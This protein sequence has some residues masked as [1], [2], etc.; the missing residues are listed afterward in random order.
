MAEDVVIERI[1]ILL[2]PSNRC[3]YGVLPHFS[4]SF[5]A[6]LERLGISCRVLGNEAGVTPSLI[7]DLLSDAPDCTLSFNGLLPDEG[8]EFF[9][10]RIG[11]PHVACLVDSPNK[12]LSLVQSPLNIITC[13]DQE[14]SS[15]FQKLGHQNTLFMPHAV[16]RDLKESCFTKKIYDVVFLGTCLDIEELSGRWVEIFGKAVATVLHEAAEIALSD[17]VSHLSAFSTALE[18]RM[19]RYGDID[20]STLDICNLLDQLEFYIRGKDRLALLLSLEG[21]EVHLFGTKS[22]SKGWDRYLQKDHIHFHGRISYLQALEVLQKSKIVLNSCP[23]IK[24]GAHE[25]IFAGYLAGALVVSGENPFL[26]TLFT[27]DEILFY[28]YGHYLEMAQK[29][30]DLL[31]NEEK[32]VEMVKRAQFKILKEHTWDHRA[33]LLLRHLKKV[34]PSVVERL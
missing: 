5:K 1:D 16:E 26:Q 14:W 32:R 17:Q 9:C 2:P 21:V 23:S 7:R 27:S 3:G 31:E 6:A 4:H 11:I 15:F 30:K 25:R 19:C 18:Q 29:M 24:Q 10:D 34:L 28:Q 8:G 20:P 22:G 12:F 13:I 33:E